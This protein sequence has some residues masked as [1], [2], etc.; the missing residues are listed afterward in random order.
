MCRMALP[1]NLS[2]RDVE[3]LMAQSGI[4]VSY[5]AIGLRCNKFGSKY[6]QRLRSKHQGYGDTFFIDEVFTKIHGKQHCL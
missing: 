1:F 6:A 5:E 3:D 2:H 4:T